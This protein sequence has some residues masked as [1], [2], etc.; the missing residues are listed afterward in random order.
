MNCPEDAPDGEIFRKESV[1]V[2]SPTGKEL[3]CGVNPESKIIEYMDN[4]IDFLNNSES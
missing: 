4:A 1:S 2:Y 3:H